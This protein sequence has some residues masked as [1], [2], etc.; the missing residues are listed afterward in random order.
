MS[1]SN[2][3]R[4]VESSGRTNKRELISQLGDNLTKAKAKSALLQEEIDDAE[5]KLEEKYR[6]RD[7]EEA[8]FEGERDTNDAVIRALRKEI[9]RHKAELEAAAVIDEEE[10]EMYL[11]LIRDR[12]P[13][14]PR[15]A[16]AAR[17]PTL[18]SHSDTI[19]ARENLTFNTSAALSESLV[20]PNPSGQPVTPTGDAV[21][22]TTLASS[23]KK[24]RA[25]SGLS[26]TPFGV[27]DRYQ[28]LAGTAKTRTAERMLNVDRKLAAPPVQRPAVVETFQPLKLQDLGEGT[29]PIR[30][31]TSAER[32]ADEMLREQVAEE[33][34]ARQRANG[35]RR[36]SFLGGIF[37]HSRK[38][39]W[40]V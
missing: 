30:E 6:K 8:E 19:R 15:H 35:T 25:I 9:A 16:P 3:M 26:D 7:A 31:K 37:G 33:A 28:P 2:N 23:A 20:D 32:E 11:E 14:P 5:T 24:E 1:D 34:A 27:P 12:R 21:V 10:A 36:G 17:S 29:P 39:S 40:G 22:P 18:P 4:P 38:P 13:S